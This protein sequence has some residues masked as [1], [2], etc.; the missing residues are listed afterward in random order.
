MAAKE[1]FD[2]VIKSVKESNLNFTM[3]L[4]PF[5][6]YI[7]IKSSFVKN[8]TP[9]PVSQ[10]LNHG[11]MEENEH[12]L[13][14]IRN[15]E[16]SS[17]NFVETIKILE[18]KIAKAEASV[19]K[20]YEER[21]QEVNTMKHALR[22][23]DVELGNLKKEIKVLDKG[24]KEKE[25]EEYKLVQKV[26]NL[27]DNLKR[28]KSEITT[29]KSEN[30]NLLRKKKS[31]TQSSSI[32]DNSSPTTTPCSSFMTTMPVPV[33]NSDKCNK[34]T[35]ST[36]LSMNTLTPCLVETNNNQPV[37][38]S[39]EALVL[40][41]ESKTCTPTRCTPSPGSPST[42]ASTTLSS[43]VCTDFPVDLM[44]QLECLKEAIKLSE[45]NFMKKWMT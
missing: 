1:N 7:T 14:Q 37:L 43:A 9:P 11:L 28:S 36:S 25:K 32:K 3:N 29:L 31:V 23:K 20:T 22:N 45:E 6:A 17:N 40:E 34:I 35:D 26:D 12:L 41:N 5:S 30:K 27:S 21:N 38:P 24:L 13:E 19:Y 10:P 2:G 8:F 16:K 39:F 42:P 33:N 4:T 18:D 44:D 15:L